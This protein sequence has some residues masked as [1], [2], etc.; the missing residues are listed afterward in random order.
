MPITLITGKP[1]A[2]KTL[3]AVKMIVEDLLPTG[4]P[5]YAQI[6]GLQYDAL[7]VLRLVADDQVQDAAARV[8]ALRHWHE[9]PDGAVIIIDECQDVFP[10]RNPAAACPD[11]I[12]KFE[13]HRHRGHDVVLLTQGPRLIDRH[14]H[15]LIDRHIH[16]FRLFG[17]RR[18]TKFEWPGVNLSPDPEQSR[19]TARRAFFSFP[20]KYFQFYQSATLHTVQRRIPWAPF[21]VLGLAAIIVPTLL[22]ITV[23]RLRD[24]SAGA[25]LDV[26]AA[27]PPGPAAAPRPACGAELV[28]RAGGLV[29]VRLGDHAIDL[30]ADAVVAQGGRAFVVSPS[31]E[32]VGLCRLVGS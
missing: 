21:A 28:A 30:P 13:T 31:S 19:D 3:A 6:N 14:L 32:L 26:A 24:A 20:R 15:D 11:Y 10:P 2:G 25:A 5:I 23:G 1:G 18:S 29:R 9:L 17:L 22:V 27:A 7:G 12:R 8:A 4:R 16:L